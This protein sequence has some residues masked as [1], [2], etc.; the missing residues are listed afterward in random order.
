MLVEERPD[1]REARKIRVD[2]RLRFLPGY[3]DVLGERERLLSVEQRVVDD[4]RAAAKLVGVEAARGAEHLECRA[5]VDV[6]AV[7]ER[8]DER[9]LPGEVG[10]DA[11]L[12]LRVVGR[13]EH[14]ARLGHECP[15]DLPA[16]VGPDG[17]VLEVGVAAAQA[18]GRGHC[19]VEA[20]VHAARVG[21]NERRQRVD[22][23]ALQLLQAAPLENEL[24]ELVRQRQLLEHFERSRLRL[25]LGRPPDRLGAHAEAI[26]E[27]LRQLL[28]R[29]DVELFARELEDGRGEP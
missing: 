15:P 18:P 5:V 11:Q 2:E 16:D 12:D 3:T 28:G 8:V 19:L 26:E 6:L 4:L 1:R 7:A 9:L 14:V 17:D 29:V 27:N 24:G 21:M 22:V 10:E 25:G 23:G 20:R 13:D